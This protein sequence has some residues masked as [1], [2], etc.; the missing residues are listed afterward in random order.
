MSGNNIDLKF[1]RCG[2]PLIGALTFTRR[3]EEVCMAKIKSVSP[4]S[5]EDACALPVKELGPAI[6]YYES[7]MSFTVISRDATTA[8]L[9]RDGVQIG[10]VVKRDHQPHE[11]GS[12]AFA[13]DDLDGLHRELS[14]CGGKPGEFGIDDWGGKQYRTFFVREEENGYCYCFYHPVEDARRDSHPK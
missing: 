11:A 6:T 4:I 1:A 3:T 14:E 12:M 5:N 8:T 9:Q 2:M 13:V 7:V 10:L